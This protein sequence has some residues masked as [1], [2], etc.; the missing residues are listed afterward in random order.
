ME[1]KISIVIPVF[2]GEKTL[3]QLVSRIN[4]VFKSISAQYELI[5]I[6][7]A[8]PDNSW[9]LIKNLCSKNLN[10]KGINL[11]RNF[12]QHYA[13]SSGLEHASG[14]W[15]IV[16]DC[17]LQDVPEEISKLFKKA[18]EG[19]D[20][21]LGIRKERGD[22]FIRKTVSTIFYKILSWLSGVEHDHRIGNFGIYRKNVVNAILLM[23]DS[24]RYFPSM[25]KWVGF[26]SIGINVK[27]AIRQNGKTSYNFKKLR[28]L[29]LD[30]ILSY[31]DR[32]IRLA[33]KMG[34]FVS[35]LSLVATLITFFRALIGK[36]E[37]QG[38][39]SII[40]SIWFLSGLI[41]A[42]IGIVG[43]YVSKTFQAAR[44]RPLFI[45]ADKINI[46]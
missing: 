28:N 37:V 33:I 29:A 24:I 36:F 38:Y 46:D 10:I 39:A 20:I 2:L 15:I 11:S 35:L 5:I 43:L 44:R 3:I 17:D 12:G 41:I 4:E 9:E 40:I 13:I 22:N 42:I 21:V 34:L 26:K 30:I 7:D 14:D 25:V 19:Y 27:H 45:I 18:L 16:M 1:E 32:P 31:S 23:G 6:N 8:S